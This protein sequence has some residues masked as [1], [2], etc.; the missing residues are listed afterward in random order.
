[1]SPTQT[2]LP[3]E[4]KSS[5]SQIYLQRPFNLWMIHWYWWSN[6]V[7]MKDW[8][9]NTI[10]CYSISPGHDKNRN[11]FRVSFSFYSYCLGTMVLMDIDSDNS[12]IRDPRLLIFQHFMGHLVI[13]FQSL[14]G[15]AFQHIDLLVQCNAVVL[16]KYGKS[17]D[18]WAFYQEHLFMPYYNVI[19]PF[20]RI[21]CLFM[22]S[23]HKKC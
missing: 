6:V 21:F 1:M 23:K 20:N 18:H 2:I 8:W 7:E 16:S 17:N 10:S 13:L 11:I 19:L 12:V 9:V 22:S 5:I 4:I 14:S 15:A 3:S